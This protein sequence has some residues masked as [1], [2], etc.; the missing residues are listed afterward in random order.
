MTPAAVPRGMHVR[1]PRD[2]CQHQDAPLLGTAEWT[3]A[4]EIRS[5]SRP[6]GKISERD[7][8]SHSVEWIARADVC[9]GAENDR[10]GI[11]SSG[12]GPYDPRS[13]PLEEGPTHSTP[14]EAP[15]RLNDEGSGQLP[16]LCVARGQR[17]RGVGRVQHG[18]AEAGLRVRAAGQ[19]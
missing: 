13:I 11:L 12:I 16:R 17:R 6:V 2:L 8:R 7:D 1:L 9:P 4:T 19:R 18:Q 5:R 14:R 3:E 15:I 10:F